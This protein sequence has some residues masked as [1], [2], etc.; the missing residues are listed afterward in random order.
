MFR[1]LAGSSLVLLLA[2]TPYSFGQAVYGSIFG[3]VTDA[4]GAVIP[5]ATVT[6][7]D[8]AKGTS[9]TVNANSSGD[10]AADHLIPDMYT[11]KVNAEGFKGF[12]QSDIQIFADTSVKV[13]AAMQVGGSDQTVEV[14]ADQV[15]QLKT[16]RADVS[17]TAL[18]H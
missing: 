1:G 14:A 6:V 13:T 15:P 2:A 16:D 12:Q 9:V 11:V 8:V 18:L 10:F 4:S 7:T 5:N 17:T 3:T